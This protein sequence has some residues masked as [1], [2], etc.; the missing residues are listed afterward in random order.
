MARELSFE[1]LLEPL[2]GGD[3]RDRLVRYATL[4]ERWSRRHS[5]VSYGSRQELVE[6]HIADSLAGRHELTGSGLLLDV[7]SGA[8]LPG[9]P[10]LAVSPAWRGVLLEPRQKRWTFLRL[11]IRELGLDAVA[12]RCRYQDLDPESGPFDIVTARA[13]GGYEGLL[14]WASNRLS[15]GGRVVLWSTEPDLARLRESSGWRV[16]SSPLPGLTHGRLVR[17]Q[18]CFT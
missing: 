9:L 15:D 17:L 5:L 3:E 10:L 6:R 8:G 12:Q 2:V 14:D 4:L 7:G 11:V 18:P 13:L 1:E 16:L